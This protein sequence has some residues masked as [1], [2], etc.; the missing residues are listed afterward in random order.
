MR[1]NTQNKLVKSVLWNSLEK[2][3]VKGTSL[4]LVLF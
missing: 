1:N 4:L 2:F 3:F